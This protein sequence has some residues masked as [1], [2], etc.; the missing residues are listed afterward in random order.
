M[1]QDML[2]AR[3]QFG[4]KQLSDKHLV[5]IS[6]TLAFIGLAWLFFNLQQGFENNLTS[7]NHKNQELIVLQGS[8]ASVVHKQSLTIIKV[9]QE[10]EFPVISFSNLNVS[11]QD[12]VTILA[13]LENDCV[14]PKFLI[15]QQQGLS[16]AK[17]DFQSK[18]FLK[19]LKI[20][21]H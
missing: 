3:K 1:L 16:N 12:N 20:V 4:D 2:Q 7:N 5:M 13:K 9:K 10:C 6:L 18:T 21:K 19:A 17:N 8:I 15:N 14:N 11:K